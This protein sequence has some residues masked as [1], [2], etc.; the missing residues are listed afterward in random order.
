MTKQNETNLIFTKQNES[1]P[2]LHI[3]ICIILYLKG[4]GKPDEL[5]THARN[6]HCLHASWKKATGD[7]TGYRVYC[8][9]G[10]SQKPEI[11]RYM[12]DA[13]TESAIISGLKPDTEYRVGISSVSTTN[14][15]ELV[16]SEGQL[17]M[18][19]AAMTVCVVLRRLEL[20]LKEM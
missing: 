5:R 3:M 20:N 12:D 13:N 1:H 19:K 15:S 2:F 14:E 4:F 6:P 17:R 16:Y 11:I 18:R 10:D 9:N 8:F 7:V